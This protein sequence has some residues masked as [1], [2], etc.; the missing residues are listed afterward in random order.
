[1]MVLCVTV[2]ASSSV[3]TSECCLLTCRHDLK[4]AERTEL[5]EQMMSL[6]SGHIYEV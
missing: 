1:M 2:S 3:F 6:I 4:V 5:L